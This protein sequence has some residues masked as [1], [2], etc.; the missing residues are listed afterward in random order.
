MNVQFLGGAGEVGR[1]AILIDESLLLDFG[2]KTGDPPQYPV[3]DVSPE[4]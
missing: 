4:A 1:S 3:G 2:T